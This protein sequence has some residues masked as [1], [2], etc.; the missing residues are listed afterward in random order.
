MHEFKINS[1]LILSGSTFRITESR[2]ITNSGD[3]G[4]KGEITWDEDYLYICIA[5]NTW[6]RTTLA[7]W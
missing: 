7:S 4:L 3:T 2:T 5:N 1:D 6:K